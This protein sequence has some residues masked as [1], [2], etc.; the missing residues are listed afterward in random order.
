MTSGGTT[1]IPLAGGTVTLSLPSGSQP[2]SGTAQSYTGTISAGWRKITGVAPSATAY[3]IGVA[4]GP[5]TAS[6][7]V[8]VQIGTG[9][10]ATTVT[11]AFGQIS[12]T[13]A[14][15]PA[16]SAP[17]AVT[18][19]VCAGAAGCATPVSTATITVATSGT[20]SY[21]FQLP[22]SSGAGDVVTFSATGYDDQTTAALTVTDGTTTTAPAVTL[23]PPPPPPPPPPPGP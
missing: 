14:L 23:S 15:S 18:A 16:P 7:S 12:G 4:D 1:P 20:A 11:A 22:P 10:V 5:V 21:T 2:S 9:I 17:T 13:V 3:T 19:T 6:G 8:S